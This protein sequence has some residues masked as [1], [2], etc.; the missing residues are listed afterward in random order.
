[1]SGGL[2]QADWRVFLR[3]RF[4]AHAKGWVYAQVGAL[5]IYYLATLPHE[6]DVV[7]FMASFV[8]ALVV[9][10]S[11]LG[12]AT[13]LRFP[14]WGQLPFCLL[15]MAGEM[16]LRHIYHRP[17]S[18]VTVRRERCI[19]NPIAHWQYCKY[20]RHRKAPRQALLAAQEKRWEMTHRMQKSSTASD[21]LGMGVFE[22][23]FEKMESHVLFW[24][25]AGFLGCWLWLWL[26]DER[27]FVA[28]LIIAFV[29]WLVG[30]V[31]FVLLIAC[32]LM[33]FLSGLLLGA[34]RTPAERL[35]EVKAGWAL[36]SE[37]LAHLVPPDSSQ[38]Q[39]A[40]QQRSSRGWILPLVIGLW[41]GSAWGKDE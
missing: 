17:W 18:R 5:T 27:G 38:R 3:H 13:V 37:E 8:A 16:A 2:S 33:A 12:I 41:I 4:P 24:Y 15:S 29:L 11:L 39:Q 28:A 31:S 34:G 21:S 26:A 20:V 14:W 32:G 22:Y 36:Q 10:G 6:L 40:P 7:F 9:V 1:M 25:W 19:A 35:A 23:A 30:T